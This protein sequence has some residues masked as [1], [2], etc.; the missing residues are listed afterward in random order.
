MIFIRYFNEKVKR[1]NIFDIKLIQGIGIAVA[2][3]L[4][5]LIPDIMSISIW[6]FVALLIICTIRP[7]YIFFL[8]R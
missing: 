5:K 7:F 1:L 6:W 8:K 2:L 3:I 4:V